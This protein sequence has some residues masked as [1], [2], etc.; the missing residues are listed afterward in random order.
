MC[1]LNFVGCLAIPAAL[2][3]H[4]W[5]GKGQSWEPTTTFILA[6]VGIIPLASLMGEATERLAERTGPTWGGL[7]NA[8]FGNAAELIIA[9]IAL[10]KGLNDIVMASLTGSILGNLL[11]VAGGAIVVGGWNREKQSFSRATAEHNAGLLMLAVGALLLP[12]MFHYTAAH[13]A[14]PHLG[15]DVHGVSMGTSI[16]LL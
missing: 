10:T 9:I 14:D 13:M 5:L 15:H 1:W 11:L 8:T 4:Y 16:I 2:L 3:I 12:A 6:G 7:L